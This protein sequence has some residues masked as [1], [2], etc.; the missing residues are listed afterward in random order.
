MTDVFNDYIEEMKNPK[1]VND[2]K[3]IHKFLS[4]KLPS[5]TVDLRYGMPSYVID[6]TVIASLASQKHYMSLYMDV[7]SIEAHREEL[8]NLDCGKSCIRFKKLDD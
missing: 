1:H 8:G 3:K 7:D 2:L 5:A 6:D 4:E